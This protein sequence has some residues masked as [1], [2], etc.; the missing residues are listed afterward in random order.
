MKIDPTLKILITHLSWCIGDFI[1]ELHSL[2]KQSLGYL[3][4][5]YL[6]GIL[7]SQKFMGI[8]LFVKLKT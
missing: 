6:S 7:T 1:N 4:Y 3:F 8:Y 5:S 2:K